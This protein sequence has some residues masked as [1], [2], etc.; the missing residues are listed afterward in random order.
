[1]ENKFK[2]VLEACKASWQTETPILRLLRNATCTPVRRGSDRDD[3]LGEP[4]LPRQLVQMPGC[5]V[6]QFRHGGAPSPRSR[7]QHFLQ[8]S[9]CTAAPSSHRFWQST[10]VCT[11]GC[12]SRR[13]CLLLSPPRSTLGCS[14]ILAWLVRVVGKWLTTLN[15]HSLNKIWHRPSLV[16]YTLSPDPAGAKSRRDLSWTTLLAGSRR[17]AGA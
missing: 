13:R 10:A 8:A 5:R 4:L 12:S 2:F 15:L 3:E 14:P 9:R 1:M 16:P 6:Q 7:V 11:N 17:L